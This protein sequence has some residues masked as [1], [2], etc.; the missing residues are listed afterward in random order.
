MHKLYYRLIISLFDLCMVPLAWFGAYWLRYNLSDIPEAAVHQ[1]VATLPWVIVIQA[2]FFWYFGVYRGIWRFVSVS[3]LLRIIKAA[4]LGCITFAILLFFYMRLENVPRSAFPL[5]IVLLI[6]L[7]GGPRLMYRIFKEWRS[8]KNKNQ[9]ALII[10]AGSAGELLVRDLLR[11]TN[12]QYLPVAFV[13][14]SI[15]KHG[16]EIHGIRVLGGC[17]KIKEIVEKKSI[18][19]ALIALPSAAAQEMQQ[20][21]EYCRSANIPFQTLPSISELASGEVTL[22]SLREVA[23]EDLLGREQVELDWQEIKKTIA[24]KTIL[25]SGGGGSIGSEICRQVAKLN[26]K[27]LVVLENSEY[28]LYQLQQEISANFPELN[29]QVYLGSVT[30][31]FLVER[32]LAETKPNIIFHAAAYK[33]VP[34][35]EKQVYVAITNNVV[36]T[37]VLASSAINAGVDKFILISTDKAVRPANVMGATKRL[38]EMVCQYYNNKNHT[39]FITVRF[40][41]V[42]GSSGSVVPLFKKQLISGGPITVTHPDITRFFMTIPEAVRLIL[43]ACV[44]SSGGEIFVLDM[45]EPIKIKFLAEQIIR[46][47]GKEPDVD[48]KIV[49]TGLRPGEK[50]H[51]ELFYQ[52]EEIMRTKHRKIMQARSSSINDDFMQRVENLQSIL[53][54]DDATKLQ[55]LLRELVPDFHDELAR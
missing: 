26:P 9:R 27:G 37:K 29:F 50:L 22:S 19:V 42:L 5:Y 13:D 16:Q 55:L 51:E 45:G 40:G 1:A 11:S 49:Y 31:K 12:H 41:N 6:I 7:L 35:L 43:Q 52:H 21:V 39:K 53:Q 47:S 23:V 54:H 28:N 32:V 4:V 44:L 10:G 8:G 33:H 30:D 24:G 38:A 3:D 34:I 14:D 48:I 20:I 46:L 36:G 2:I 25:I 17:S 15:S 18:D